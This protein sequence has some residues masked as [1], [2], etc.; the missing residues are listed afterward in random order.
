MKKQINY[1]IFLLWMLPLSCI[2][3][4][5]I[6]PSI[7]VLVWYASQETAS[8]WSSVVTEPVLN[9]MVYTPPNNQFH[10]EP[11]FRIGFLYAPGD[12][13]WDSSIEWTYFASKKE[14]NLRLA[15][16]IIAPE[17][18]SGFLSKDLFF[19]ADLHWKLTINMIDVKASHLFNVGKAFTLRPAIGIKAGT[20]RQNINTTWDAVIYVST[21]NLKHHFTGIGPSFGLESQWHVYPTLSLIGNFSTAFMWGNWNIEDIYNR[22]RDFLG[23]ITPTTISTEISHSKLGTMMLSYFLGIQWQ[24]AAKYPITFKAGYETQLWANQ[25][26]LTTFQILP[27]HGDL[28]LQGGTCRIQ[29]DL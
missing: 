4:A 22:P 8:F 23:L 12:H 21:E 7:D 5:N 13:Y 18:F 29:I 19:G 17:F 1:F 3:A 10:W 11:G 16:Q 25:L 24:I 15:E 27:L 2:H 26:R 28:T 9:E 6:T 14:N 20:I